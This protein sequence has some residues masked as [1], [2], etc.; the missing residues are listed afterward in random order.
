MW[1]ALQWTDTFKIAVENDVNIGFEIGHVMEE[2]QSV[3]DLELFRSYL[4]EDLRANVSWGVDTSHFDKEQDSG[5]KAVAAAIAAGLATPGHAKDAFFDINR[6]GGR[7]RQHGLPFAEQ[8]GV[9]EVFG[10][11]NPESAKAFVEVLKLAEKQGKFDWAVVEG[12]AMRQIRCPFQGMKIAAE[13]IRRIHSGE[14]PL[15]YE[16]IQ[17]DPWGGNTFETFAETNVTVSELLEL[18]RADYLK[19]C[20][21]AELHGVPRP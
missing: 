10:M 16:E 11:G 21:L 6:Q 15:T 9:F 2:I 4:P 1:L 17:V 13:N 5:S 3:R 7:H 8:A 18:K 12:E 14:E 19:L 20:A